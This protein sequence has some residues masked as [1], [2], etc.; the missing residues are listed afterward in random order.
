MS[1][2]RYDS[3]TQAR[4]AHA[5]ARSGRCDE[6]R[7]RCVYLAIMIGWHRWNARMANVPRRVADAFLKAAVILDAQ[8]TFKDLLTRRR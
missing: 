5:D 1:R 4:R 8:S 7:E 6:H 2:R 3:V